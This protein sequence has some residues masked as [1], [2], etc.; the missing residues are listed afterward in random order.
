MAFGKDESVAQW[1]VRA[2]GIDLKMPAEIEDGQEVDRGKRA[3][4]V[5]G[6]GG[7]EHPDDFYPELACQRFKVHLFI[8]IGRECRWHENTVIV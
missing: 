3:S 7:F 1:I 2:L 6:A 4:G 8:F 5:A